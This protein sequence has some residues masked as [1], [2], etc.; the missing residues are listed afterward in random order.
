MKEGK[1]VLI[2]LSDISYWDMWHIGPE[3]LTYYWPV[4][5][6]GESPKYGLKADEAGEYIK[7]WLEYKDNYDAKSATDILEAGDAVAAEAAGQ[8]R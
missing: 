2:H 1:H 3:P 6:I 7:K 8:V 4:L 5:K